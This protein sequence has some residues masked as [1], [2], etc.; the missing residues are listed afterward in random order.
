MAKLKFGAKLQLIFESVKFLRNKL[1]F[2][3]LYLIIL[4]KN[5]RFDVFFI[6]NFI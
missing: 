2:Y 6:R 4:N 5:H 3:S 1:A